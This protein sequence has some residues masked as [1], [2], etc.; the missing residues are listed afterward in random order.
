MLNEILRRNISSDPAPHKLRIGWGTPHVVSREPPIMKKG[1]PLLIAPACSM[2]TCRGKA[3]V[4]LPIVPFSWPTTAT[5]ATSVLPFP[6]APQEV[7]VSHRPNEQG[8]WLETPAEVYV[9][10]A[11]G[12]GTAWR[13]CATTHTASEGSAWEPWMAEKGGTKKVL[14]ANILLVLVIPKA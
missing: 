11:L 7:L 10:D 8:T 14:D 4:L 6:M 13:K 9:C 12:G 5:S 1:L 2:P 3:W